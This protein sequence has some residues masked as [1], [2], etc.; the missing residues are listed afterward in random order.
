MKRTRR[1][2]LL[3]AGAALQRHARALAR[4]LLRALTRARQ[5]RPGSDR[6]DADARR[7]RQGHRLR[8]GP[9][10]GLSERVGDEMRRQVPHPLVE[11]VDDRAR[12]R[13]READARIPAS[14]RRVRA[15]WSRDAR[16]SSRASTLN[17]SSLSKTEALLT[18]QASGPSAFTA[19]GMSARAA[20]SSRK[21]G[22]ERDRACRLGRDR[23]DH[24]LRVVARACRNERR[25]HSRPRPAPARWRGRCAAPRR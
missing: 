22:G 18:R 5:S 8:Q 19:A 25:R 7:Q 17:A 16:P 12:M 2:D 10:P 23:G 4:E 3:R 11:H 6:V 1:G 21:I 20:C 14:A 24:R 15:D 9:K 13:S